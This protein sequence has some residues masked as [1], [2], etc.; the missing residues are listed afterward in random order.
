[1]LIPASLILRIKDV[2]TSTAV[3]FSYKAPGSRQVL[4]PTV[5]MVAGEKIKVACDGAEEALFVV[6]AT[7]ITTIA[8]FLTAYNA[9]SAVKGNI[10]KAAFGTDVATGGVAAGVVYVLFVDADGTVSSI[11]KGTI[12]D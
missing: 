8:Q 5:S 3:T 4:D 6:S 9:S 10:L 11:K 12:L 7:P 2:I 1:M